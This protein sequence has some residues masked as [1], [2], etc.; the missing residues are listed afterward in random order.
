MRSLRFVFFISTKLLPANS[1]V[2]R[3]FNYA[4][5]SSSSPATALR[6]TSI[7]VLSALRISRLVSLTLVIVPIT[8][9]VVMMRSPA[10]NS[11]RLLQFSL[12]S[13]LRPDQ[14]HVKDAM[15]SSIGTNEEISALPPP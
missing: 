1:P 13:L 2:A 10:F 8:P 11:D 14:E 15:I 12:S 4:F 9:P 6:K 3:T 7:M 5:F